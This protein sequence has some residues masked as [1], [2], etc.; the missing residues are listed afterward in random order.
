MELSDARL[1][2]TV[3]VN[4]TELPATLVIPVQGRMEPRAEGDDH[5]V[6]TLTA[7][8]ALARVELDP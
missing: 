5:A 8:V 2:C 1:P 4:G 6:V 3:T 7:D